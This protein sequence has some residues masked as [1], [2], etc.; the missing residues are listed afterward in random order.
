MKKSQAELSSAA[1]FALKKSINIAMEPNHAA[2]HVN[3]LQVYEQDV[4][5]DEMQPVVVQ[6]AASAFK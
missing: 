6:Y 2:Q 4:L 3:Y 5:V 1:T